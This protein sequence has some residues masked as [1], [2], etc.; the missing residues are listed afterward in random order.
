MT[1]AMLADGPEE[2]ADD[3]SESPAPYDEK[4]RITRG[5]DQH[6]CRVAMDNLSSHLYVFKSSEG[7]L[8]GFVELLSRFSQRIFTERQFGNDPERG[9]VLWIRPGGHG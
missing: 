5:V 9:A 1:D 7:G 2:G 8:D 6:R 4:S 3:G